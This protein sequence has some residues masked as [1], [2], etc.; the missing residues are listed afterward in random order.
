MSWAI[1]LL[2][3]HQVSTGILQGLGKT[4]IPVI[5]MI[6]AAIVKVFLNWNLTAMPTLGIK[7]SS[8]A[9]VADIGI[10]ANLNLLFIKKYTA[11]TF[12]GRQ[13]LKTALC[14]A[15]MGGAVMLVLSLVSRGGLA[16]FLSIMDAVPVYI[17][18]LLLLKTLTEEELLEIPFL[19]R[20]MAWLGHK[21]G[22]LK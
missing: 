12:E 17:L 13:L 4:R 22:L 3:L 7:G 9:T 18:L 1:F 19:G 16:L 14:A 20:R 11:F 21:L 2:G 10:A 6:I 5:N 8:W 15:V